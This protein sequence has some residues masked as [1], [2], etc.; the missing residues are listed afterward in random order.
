[1]PEAKESGDRD[2]L[3]QLLT[4]IARTQGLQRK[5]DDAH[6][7]LDDVQKDMNAKTATAEIRFFLRGAGCSIRLRNPS[8][9]CRCFQ[10]P[11][12]WQ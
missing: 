1:L 9:L 7:T 3:L 10:K 5:F 2:Y 11:S 4:Q 12:I 6:K 8:R